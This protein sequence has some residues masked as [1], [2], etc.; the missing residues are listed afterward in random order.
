[1]NTGYGIHLHLIFICLFTLI[2]MGGQKAKDCFNM[3][4]RTPE[5]LLV[6]ILE[7]SRPYFLSK[8]FD[9]LGRICSEHPLDQVSWRQPLPMSNLLL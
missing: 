4:Q 8:A 1:M 2:Q 6:S 5:Q 9:V 3:M 7:T